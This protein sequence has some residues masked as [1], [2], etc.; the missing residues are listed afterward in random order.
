[1][2]KIR[3]LGVVCT[4]VLSTFLGSVTCYADSFDDAVT[5]FLRGFEYC[6]EAKSHLSAHRLTDARKALQEY[7]QI[8]KQA[9][10]INGDIL[11]TSK[12]G[13]DGNL[14]YCDRVERDVE[15][16]TGMPTMNK[17]LAACDAAQQSLKNGKPDDA[18]QHY[19]DFKSLR[20]EA[21]KQAPSLN[22]IFTVK[23]QI[24]RC[25]RIETKIT[26]YGQRQKARQLSVEAAQE[27]SNNYLASCQ[28]TL[29]N[30]NREK[31]DDPVLRD[32]RQGLGSALSHKK[33]VSDEVLAY[34]V[35]EQNPQHPAK[36]AID[37][38]LSAGDQCMTKLQGTILDKEK[39][40]TAIKQQFEHYNHQLTSANSLCQKARTGAGGP[41]SG[42]DIS[43]K[44]YEDAVKARDAIRNSLAKD[45]NYGTYQGWDSVTGI[46]S[47]MK[48]L[49][50]CLNEANTKLNG[51][52]S[53]MISLKNAAQGKAVAPRTPIAV[54]INATPVTSSVSTPSGTA[55][56]SQFSGTLR[57]LN[58]PPEFA[59]FYV[60]DGSL[61]KNPEITI[62]RSGFDATVYYA[63]SGA[64]IEF[65][66]KD[67][68]S[69][70]L[71]AT[72]ELIGFTDNL[73][74]LQPRQNK[75]ATVSWPANAIVTL[76]SDRGT[77]P[78]SYIANITSANYLQLNFKGKSELHFSFQNDSKSGTAY[79]LMPD[80]DPL[81][82]TL[83]KGETKSLAISR[84]G[85]PIGSLLVEGE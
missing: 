69:H 15:V 53:R 76:R 25:E 59:L 6:K 68:I 77:F 73:A 48:S 17:A 38:N 30:L 33:S 22:D 1:M 11:N 51:L 10:A 32:A 79:L 9:T 28:R 39:E 67:N 66:N 46:E 81:S 37:K 5:Q 23:N 56:A 71:T 43:K 85:V 7:H 80:A 55:P 49:N 27:E 31:V 12:R 47:G 50:S 29:E 36:L 78:A 13:M 74:R 63:S 58:V 40:L 82:F 64:R 52:Y 8:L 61:P 83:S 35:F 34:E 60:P 41:V 2:S 44:D 42:Y 14:K 65:K 72:N 3:P 54:E 84:D 4:F 45:S 19:G 20:D 24:S 26:T 18:Q 57:V 21:L 16:E 70:R 75:S 62:D